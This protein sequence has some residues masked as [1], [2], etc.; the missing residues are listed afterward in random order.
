MSIRKTPIKQLSISVFGLLLSLVMTSCLSAH[1]T[2]EL[3]MTPT[4]FTVGDRSIEG[5]RGTLLVQENRERADSSMIEIAFVRLRHP[6]GTNAAPIVY[7]PGG[8]GQPVLEGID[9]FVTAYQ[10]YLDI[11]GDGD[12]LL[13]EQRGVGASRPRLDCPGLLSRPTNSPLSASIM[14]STHIRYIEA[15][16]DHWKKQGVDLGGYHVLSMAADIDELRASLGYQQIKIIGE[17]FGA[18]HAFAL[19]QNYG[20]HIE[21]AA[22]SAVIGPDDMFEQPLTVEQQLAKLERSSQDKTGPSNEA[23]AL[24]ALISTVL[25]D[26]DEHPIEVRVPTDDGELPLEIGRYDLALATVTLSRQTAFLRQLPKLY[27]EVSRGEL[28]W[29]ARWSANIR[30]GHQTNLASLAITCA[31]GASDQRRAAIATQAAES[32][33]GDAVDLLGADACTP[34]AGLAHGDRFQGPVRGDMPVL[35]ISGALDPRAPP[36]N[37]EALLR[38]LPEALHVVFPDVSHD[39]GPARNVQ[40]GLAYHFLAHGDI[41]PGFTAAARRR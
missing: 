30:R 22:L 20:E 36:A 11:G 10:A 7:L 29:L 34:L 8:P 4:V 1:D 32:P 41:M 27:Q 23:H 17:S 33:L 2:P 25:H 9:H 40:L 28:S 18:H 35:M 14:G 37:A 31:S 38:D 13:V 19:I 16:V 21:R 26:L 15:C 12:M 6:N 5:D 3:S 39:F 24:P